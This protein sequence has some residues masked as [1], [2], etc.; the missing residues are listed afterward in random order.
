[1][2]AVHGALR[3]A[4]KIPEWD[5]HARLIVHEPH[6]FQVSLRLAQPDRFTMVTIDCFSGRSLEAKRALY[7]AIVRNLAALGIPEDHVL[8]LLRE[9]PSQ[10][11][12]VGGGQAACDIDL[13]F[14]VE[15]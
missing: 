11:W 5:R 8:I 1:M 2:D 14:K 10:D 12:G 6:R 9:A 7:R 4:F 3:E 13:G 15:V